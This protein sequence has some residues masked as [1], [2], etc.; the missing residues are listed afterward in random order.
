MSGTGGLVVEETPPVGLR[1][2]KR[3]NTRIRIEQAA[4]E[5]FEA[6]G[7]EQTTVDDIA[8]RADVSRTSVF[9]YFGS[10]DD[11]IFSPERDVFVALRTLVLQR[12][13]LPLDEV[14]VR[15]ADHFVEAVPESRRRLDIIVRTPK[16]MARV[17]DIESRW[18]LAIAEDLAARRG[19]AA[20]RT[21]EDLI[22][23]KMALSAYFVPVIEW[24]STPPDTPLR[25]LVERATKVIKGVPDASRALE[26]VVP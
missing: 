9:R 10:K 18:E 23:S 4:M 16:L 3:E 5:L 26:G 19:P 21:L 6:Q 22:L 15:F 1:A 17:A 14:M 11:I 25:D 13:Y 2:R 12:P 7:F 20:V 8:E 24:A